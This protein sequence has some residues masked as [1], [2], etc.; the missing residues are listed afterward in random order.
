VHKKVALTQTDYL[1][2]DFVSLLIVIVS[3]HNAA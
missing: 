2:H 3:Q 1:S